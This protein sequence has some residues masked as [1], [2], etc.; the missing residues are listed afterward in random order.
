MTNLET[1][2]ELLGKK[3]ERQTIL[4][5]KSKELENLHT[6]ISGS[7]KGRWF[8]SSYLLVKRTLSIFIGVALI[9]IALF[10]ILFPEIILENEEIREDLI[11]DAR[12]HYIE[13]TGETFA[14]TLIQATSDDRDFDYSTATILENI[15]KGMEK[16]LEQEIIDAIQFIAVLLLILAFVFL[17]I[18]RMTRKMKTRN[19]K[20]SRSET[21]TQ[22]IINNFRATI[23]EEEQELIILQDMIR[24]SM[25]NKTSY[26]STNNSSNN[27]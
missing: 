19:Q 18:A 4:S 27:S 17:Y 6:V 20:I 23:Q 16:A 11:N 21:L 7:K 15:E 26:N 3:I 12:R 14:Q 25:K 9:V 8:G 24:T 1:L 22:E 2:H 5:Q 10:F 13:T